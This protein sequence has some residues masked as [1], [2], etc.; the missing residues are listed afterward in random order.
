MTGGTLENPRS[1]EPDDEAVKLLFGP[2]MQGN[3][4]KAA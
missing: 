2:T 1:V 3:K 4:S